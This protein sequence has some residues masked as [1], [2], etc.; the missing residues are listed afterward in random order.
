VDKF[1]YELKVEQ[2]EKLIVRG[3][4]ST[5]KKIADTME[6]KR[7][8][9]TK[10]LCH[11]AEL[12]AQAGDVQKALHIY[13]LAYNASARGLLVLERMIELAVNFGQ[14]D[15]AEEICEEYRTIGGYDADYYLMKFQISESR[16]DAQEQR[17]AYLEKY[18]NKELDEEALYRLAWLYDRTGRADDCVRIC[19][20]IIDFFCCGE[21]V[22]RAIALKRNHAPLTKYQERRVT[23]AARYEENYRKFLET[24][25]ESEKRERREQQQEKQIREDALMEK[26][27]DALGKQITEIVEQNEKEKQEI[28]LEELV[29]DEELMSEVA[30][31]TALSQV[32]DV[33]ETELPQ[34]HATSQEHEPLISE[35]P[36]ETPWFLK[37]AVEAVGKIRKASEERKV[38]EEK[39]L[40]EAFPEEAFMN[41]EE[42]SEQVPAQEEVRFAEEAPEK[43]EEVAEEA[44]EEAEELSKEEPKEAVEVAEEAPEKAEE[45]SEE[46]PEEIEEVT[47][48]TPEVTEELS[49]E[50]PE[51]AVE[52]SEETSEVTEEVAEK[53]PEE[54]EKLSEE[55][56]EVTEEVAEE[57]PEEAE[58]LSEEEPEEAEEV[59]EE[60]PEKAEEVSEEAPEEAEELSEEAPEEAEKLSEETLEE[61]ETEEASKEEPEEAVEGSDEEHVEPVYDEEASIEYEEDAAEVDTAEKE[62]TTVA[63]AESDVEEPEP[64]L[65]VST[66]REL[67]KGK[68]ELAA[69]DLVVPEGSFKVACE[70][71]ELG[72]KYA[73]ALVR[74][75]PEEN[76]CDHV[77]RTSSRQV[78][79]AK[80]SRIEQQ[81][82]NDILLITDAGQLS[83]GALES[84]YLWMKKS[85]DNRVIFVDKQQQLES[86]EKRKPKLMKRFPETYFYE[87]KDT[88]EW[89]EL[90]DSY[91]DENDCVLDDDAFQLFEDYLR[92][93]EERG[94][95]VLGITLKD[96]VQDALHQATKFS[97]SNMM[98]SIL[99][100]KYDEDGLLIL[101]DRHFR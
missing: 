62:Q 21:T 48:E 60:A 87:H 66:R 99:N 8:K 32:E 94:D 78:N 26:Q 34:E 41:E 7:E 23:D 28:H 55:E 24:Q 9:D 3:D 98:S 25:E 70:D 67:P 11:V 2:I 47:E 4:Y 63:A 64:T 90:V 1:E 97:F 71:T 58:E 49:T 95:V 30:L 18:C 37:K 68:S 88:E 83:N 92:D 33:P 72:V 38:E 50:E 42:P 54:A 69:L 35:Q 59:A 85:L 56:P 15:L 6:W 31:P 57:T 82:D 52:V 12:Y 65:E 39:A 77:A 81:L 84:I 76:R 96:A 73:I 16:G 51:E 75:V 29:A 93:K 101:C 27:E 80:F 100:T 14:L 13:N 40:E 44:S 36:E 89:L 74:M 61:Q 5:A 86:L 91:V 17:I 46:E 53:E 10:L 22:E 19:D 79:K 43:T 45:L 20:Y